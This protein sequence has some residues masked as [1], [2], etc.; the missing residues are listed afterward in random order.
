MKNAAALRIPPIP[1]I[2][3]ALMSAVLGFFTFCGLVGSA[4]VAGSL[5]ALS[6]TV[7]VIV[8]NVVLFA[9]AVIVAVPALMALILPALDTV[10]TFSS[11]LLQVIVSVE[12]AGVSVTVGVTSSPTLMLTETGLTVIPVAGTLVDVAFTVIVA[13]PETLSFAFAVIVTVPAFLPVTTP[14]ALTVATVESL[15]LQVTVSVEFVGVIVAVRLTVAPTLTFAVA[16]L[17]VTPVA[18]TCGSLESLV[19]K[20]IVAESFVFPATS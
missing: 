14:L 15:L 19:V 11:L 8:A 13:V 20:L 1:A 12:F 2:A 3:G 16:G 7:T 5:V 4:G 17:T 18:G 10:A 6:C 9:V